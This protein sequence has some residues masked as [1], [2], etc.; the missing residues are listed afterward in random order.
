MNVQKKLNINHYGAIS[1]QLYKI[2]HSSSYFCL[3]KNKYEPIMNLSVNNR[4]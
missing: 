1:I 2:I 3:N 4:I